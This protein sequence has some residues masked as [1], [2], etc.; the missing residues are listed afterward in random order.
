MNKLAILVSGRGT[1]MIALHKATLDG[2]LN[3]Q[4]GLVISN[5]EKAPALD[6]CKDNSLHHKV[7]KL[8]DYPSRT[9]HAKAMIDEI[10]KAGCNLVVLAGYMLLVPENFVNHFRYRLL[11]IHPALLPSFPG[12]DGIK[13]AFDYGVKFTGVS[14]I[15]VSH[16]C[17]DGEIVIQKTVEVLKTDTL[18]TLEEKIHKVEHEIFWQAV[19]VVLDGKFKING[20]KVDIL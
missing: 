15:F 1:N 5:K 18:E 11:N 20:R 10:D 12:I 16:G 8:K 19:K 4:I 3:A 17:D 2:R 9:D 14:V 7:F 6:Y 13:Q